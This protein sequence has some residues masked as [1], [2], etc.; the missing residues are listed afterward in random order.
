MRALITVDG[1]GDELAGV[2]LYRWLR[3]DPQVA[4]DASVSFEPSS[5]GSTMGGFEVIQAIVA[6]SLGLGSLVVS[7]L[8]W[9]DSRPRP[10]L[11][12]IRLQVGEVAVTVE[13]LGP[14]EVRRVVDALTAAG[15]DAE[16]TDAA[17]AREIAG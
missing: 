17:D 1:G 12:V 8:A 11:P 2:S 3:D 9:R 5:S 14:D 13:G 6:N 10:V 15:E 4:R 16:E 7:F